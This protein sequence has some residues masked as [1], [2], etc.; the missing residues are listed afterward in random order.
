MTDSQIEFDV[1]CLNR[2]LLKKN[3]WSADKLEIYLNSKMGSK[4]NKKSN[5]SQTSSH[6]KVNQK[7]LTVDRPEYILML[8]LE[9]FYLKIFDK[10]NNH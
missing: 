2:K 10:E 8:I 1:R 9:V 7:T 5:Q 3:A 6:F 4:I